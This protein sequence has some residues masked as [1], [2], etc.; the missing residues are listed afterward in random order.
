MKRPARQDLD[1][2]SEYDAVVFDIYGTLLLAPPGRVRSDPTA[3]GALREVIESFGHTAPEFPSEGLARLVDSHHARASHPFPEIDLRELWRELLD[4]PAETSMEE[5][6]AA[7]E[8]VWHP[9]DWMD[10]APAML[11]RLQGSGTLMGLLSNAQCHT[12]G[13]LAPCQGFFDPDLTILSYQHRRA[14]PSPQLF[15]TMAERL[16]SRGIEPDRTLFIG[17]DPLQD[18]RPAAAAG[19]RTALF[20]GHPSSLR[21]GR[22]TPDLVL[23]HWDQFTRFD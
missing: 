6:V 16:A 1:P 13:S 23:K 14:K 17:N 15:N 22:C 9:A 21:P 19:F 10:G 11:H 18:I 5:L 8:A 3:D 7:T 2:A 12:L 4:L 20:S